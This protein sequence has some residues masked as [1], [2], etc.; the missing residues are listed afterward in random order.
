MRTKVNLVIQT[1]NADWHSVRALHYTKTCL[2]SQQD[3]ANSS[4]TSFYLSAKDRIYFLQKTDRAR[5]FISKNPRLI[6]FTGS[7][8]E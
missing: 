4:D 6:L 3:N 8:S 1:T 2:Q 5:E 7:F